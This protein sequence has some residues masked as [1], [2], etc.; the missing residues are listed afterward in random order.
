MG[1]APRSA[2][3]RVDPTQ[4]DHPPPP[5]PH[6]LLEQGPA[7]GR[8]AGRY[9]TAG[10]GE[11]G[12][13]EGGRSFRSSTGQECIRAVVSTHTAREQRA[14]KG[15]TAPS[16]QGDPPNLK[17][18]LIQVAE[19]HRASPLDAPDQNLQSSAQSLERTFSLTGE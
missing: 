7:A 16:L 6:A 13:A 17:P 15:G 2:W 3:T 9:S 4:V 14:G 19:R 18:D 8:L 12:R 1:L 5:T 10:R 11:E